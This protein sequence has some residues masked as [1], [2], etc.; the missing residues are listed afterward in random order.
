MATERQF[1]QRLA[2]AAMVG[3]ATLH[4]VYF[5]IHGTALNG[6][7]YAAIGVVQVLLALFLLKG[8]SFASRLTILVNLVLIAAFILMQTVG[9][10]VGMRPEPIGVLTVLRKGLEL[11]AVVAL[12]LRT[13]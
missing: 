7:L 9:P 3:A 2:A 13:K 12:T 10:A 5:S 11:G 4:F 6:G 1:K 8:L